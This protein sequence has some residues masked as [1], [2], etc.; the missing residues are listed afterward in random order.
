MDFND[1][2]QEAIKLLNLF[3]NRVKWTV[4]T[5]SIRTAETLKARNFETFIQKISELEENPNNRLKILNVL[6]LKPKLVSH[7]ISGEKAVA[8]ARTTSTQFD[9][10]FSSLPEP[11]ND[12]DFINAAISDDPASQV[13]VE[14]KLVLAKQFENDLAFVFAV[15]REVTVKEEL[16]PDA[17]S[18]EYRFDASNGYIYRIKNEIKLCFDVIFYRS[19][20]NVIEVRIDNSYGFSTDTRREARQSVCSAFNK[21]T[22][23]VLGNLIPLNI[24]DLFPAVEAMHALPVDDGRVV[25]LHFVTEEGGVKSNKKRVRGSGCIL[26]E[27]FH[28]GG[29]ERIANQLSTYRIARAWQYESSTHYSEPELMLP[30]TL[31]ML[32]TTLGS[33]SPQLTEAIFTKCVNQSDHE[34]LLNKLLT[35]LPE[36][37]EA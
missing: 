8:L 30:G 36:E 23:N 17:V 7:C 35:L 12:E 1:L 3:S 34:M 15:H 33:T 32:S 29:C 11:G 14:P 2:K 9:E 5:K 22:E 31:K 28:K 6:A 10:L 24:V 21:L 27:E 18:D 26:T 37:A 16:P 13:I 4:F 20:D 25:E 19:S